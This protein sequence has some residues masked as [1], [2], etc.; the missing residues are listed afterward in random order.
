MKHTSLNDKWGKEAL[1]LGWV[2]VPTSLLFLQSQLGIS[3]TGLNVLM[4]LIM[5]WW[6]S[7][8]RPHP[9]QEAMAER[10]GVSPRTVQREIAALVAMGLL[11]KKHTPVHHPTYRGRNLYD[12]SPLV[13]KLNEH[14][15]PL[16]HS[17]KNKR[18]H[19]Q[20]ALTDEDVIPLTNEPS[21]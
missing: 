14:A 4:Q 1:S 8:G 2:A 13:A 15:I 16:N 6:G 20:H 9:S 17:L 10:M 5:H 7:E 19:A 11:R 12:L 3:P 18:E 21:P